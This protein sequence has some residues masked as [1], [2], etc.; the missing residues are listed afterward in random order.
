VGESA[1]NR[2]IDRPKILI[3]SPHPVIGAGIETVLRIEDLY[4]LRRATNLADAKT[5][6][7]SWPADAALVD[8]VLLGGDAVDLQIPC[9]ILAGD[10]ESGAR[11]VAKVPGARGWLLKDAPP[12]RL[13]E[14]VDRSVGIIRVRPDVRG[15]LGMVV[16]AVIVIVFVAAVALFLWRFVLS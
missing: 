3:V 10:A 5:A 16:A 12:S 7:E 15:T 13:V 11:L 6:A 2:A 1:N 14:A 9:T 8:S 4:D